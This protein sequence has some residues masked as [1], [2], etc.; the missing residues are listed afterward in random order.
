MKKGYD[1]LLSSDQDT[2]PGDHL[3]ENQLRE[4]WHGIRKRIQLRLGSAEAQ[5]AEG[6]PWPAE[7][8]GQ[9]RDQAHGR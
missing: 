8:S 2:R 6:S 7:K 3:L 4:K 9:P 1:Y 5:V